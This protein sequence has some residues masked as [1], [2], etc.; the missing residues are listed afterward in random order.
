MK[1]VYQIDDDPQTLYQ[2][3][4]WRYHMTLTARNYG[5]RTKT[6]PK[7]I[8]ANLCGA[9]DGCGVSLGMTR[10]DN[11]SRTETASVSFRF[12]YSPN[13]GHWRTSDNTGPKNWGVVANGPT[14]HAANAWNTCF[15]TDG[16]YDRHQDQGDKNTGM[17]L[18]VRNGYGNA[19]RT[20]ELTLIP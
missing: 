18:L 11:D 6:I 4:L 1:V 13:D 10:W 8:L 15:F 14:E 20:C 9:R 12:Y 17:Q 19:G 2:K 3:P 16:T 5:G 7:E